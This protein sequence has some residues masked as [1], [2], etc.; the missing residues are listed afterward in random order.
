VT[1]DP[2]VDARSVP[3]PRSAVYSV[4]LDGEAVLLDQDA[5]RLHHLNATATLVWA[6][7]DGHSPLEAIAADLGAALGVDPA[8]VLQD[9]IIVVRSLAD[10]GL[11]SLEPAWQWAGDVLARRS[12]D[13]WLVMAPGAGGPSTL[14]GSAAEVWEFLDEPRTMADL[15]GAL[16][17][18]YAVG[19][20]EL[21]TD[22][23][24]VLD[25]LRAKGLVDVVGA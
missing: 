19:E 12:L 25:D 7:L 8:V 18:R 5:N 22:L 23:V 10:E 21:R 1:A 3:V 6:C 9:T 20:D 17:A 4:E 14:A 13:A 24:A 15:I 11:I 16:A 2:P